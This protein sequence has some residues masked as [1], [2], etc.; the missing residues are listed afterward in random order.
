MSNLKTFFNLVSKEKTTIHKKMKDRA[1]T[2]EKVDSIIRETGEQLN[3]AEKVELAKFIEEKRTPEE[4]CTFLD[5]SP[6][7]HKKAIQTILQA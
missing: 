6:R 5:V 1:K 4:I 2:L 7:E 3:Q